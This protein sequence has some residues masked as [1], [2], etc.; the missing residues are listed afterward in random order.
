MNGR[1]ENILDASLAHRASHQSF[2]LADTRAIGHGNGLHL[3][4]GKQLGE[5]NDIFLFATVRLL[6]PFSFRRGVERL[7]GCRGFARRGGLEA[8]AAFAAILLG[9]GGRAG[10]LITGGSGGGLVRG[11]SRLVLGRGFDFG[12]RGGGVLLFAFRGSR[13]WGRAL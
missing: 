1:P 10:L 12:G 4:L 6:Y 9:L 5:R 11:G 13:Q 2:H 7:A 8:G 3:M